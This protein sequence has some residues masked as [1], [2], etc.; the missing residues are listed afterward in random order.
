MRGKFK[1]LAG[2]VIV[3]T[4][5]ASGVGLETARLAARAGAAVIL[6]GRD[7]QAVRAACEDISKTGGRVHPVAGDPATPEGC[8]RIARAAVARFGRIDSWIEAS[9]EDFALAHAA[10]AVTDHLAADEPAALVGF[11]R[12]IGK[13]ARM[14]L[15]A[16]KGQVAATLV[17]LPKDWRHDSPATA[18]A[19]AALHAA[20]KPMGEMAVAPEGKGLTAVTEVKK[21]PGI[22]VG[23][24]LV[25][26]AGV[27]VWFGRGRIAQVAS[28]ARPRI[29]RALRRVKIDAEKHKQI[30]SRSLVTK[31]PRQAAKLGR[32]LR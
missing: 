2:Q 6:A 25:T 3:V 22:M 26:L 15:R 19:Q 11:G 31:P 16:A 20:A 4:G 9:G 23:V 32:I 5:A 1:P 29:V 30:Q 17:R 21:H 13:D 12:R 10:K 8:D 7:E 27:A 28:A 14:A 24:G 18:A